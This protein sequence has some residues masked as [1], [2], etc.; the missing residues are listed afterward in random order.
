[1]RS[2]QQKIVA[3]GKRHVATGAAGDGR[4]AVRALFGWVRGARRGAAREAR[5]SE[6]GGAAA[7]RR[8]AAA[9]RPTL[10]P[11]RPK[12]S[13]AALALR[14]WGRMGRELRVQG[15]VIWN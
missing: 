9:G 4:R 10:C 14:Y 8:D 11:V 12:H 15:S 2:W 3:A 13:D 1:M 5:G 6:E 7:A